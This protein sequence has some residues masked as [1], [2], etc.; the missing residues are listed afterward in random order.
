MFWDARFINHVTR[1][2]NWDER[3]KLWEANFTNALAPNKK[4]L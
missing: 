1:T 2:I 3:I 4:N